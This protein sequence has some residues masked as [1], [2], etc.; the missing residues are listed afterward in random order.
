MPPE[1]YGRAKP[2]DGE[3]ICVFERL[4]LLLMPG[5]DVKLAL[6]YLFGFENAVGKALP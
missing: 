1:V 5:T 2:A 6:E 3:V 4:G